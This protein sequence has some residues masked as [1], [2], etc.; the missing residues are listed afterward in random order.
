MS[1]LAAAQRALTALNI[2]P[3]VKAWVA[4][5]RT[6]SRAG[7]AEAPLAGLGVG[8]ALEDGGR[9]VARRLLESGLERC[10]VSAVG[11]VFM[12]RCIDGVALVIVAADADD[13]ALVRKLDLVAQSLVALERDAT[14]QAAVDF[15]RFRLAYMEVAGAVGEFALAREVEQLRLAGRPL[16]RAA[17]TEMASTLVDSVAAD[18][19]RTL[20]HALNDLLRDWGAAPLLTPVPPALPT[21]PIRRRSSTSFAAVTMPSAPALPSSTT[22]LPR[23]VR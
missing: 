14:K 10:R 8:R 5:S 11:H 3:G 12:G 16:D 7:S 17:L 4:V 2:V 23:I 15:A 1:K 19:Q 20:R 22:P 18:A 13:A 9:E 21:P 6:E